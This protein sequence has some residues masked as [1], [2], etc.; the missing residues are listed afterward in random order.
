MRIASMSVAVLSAAMVASP[1]SAALLSVDFNS[2]QSSVPSPGTQPGFEGAVVG[3]FESTPLAYTFG[4]YTVSTEDTVVDSDGNFTQSGSRN[5]SV[6]DPAVAPLFGDFLFA[7]SS[8][9]GRF[10]LK[11]EGLDANTTYDVT[12]WSYDANSSRAVNISQV[13][14]PLVAG[15]IAWVGAVQPDDLSDYSLTLSA[16]SDVAGTLFF[17]VANPLGADAV[18]NGF[19]IAVPEPG[20]LMLAGFGGALLLVRRRA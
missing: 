13:G 14:S 17:E 10:G 7:N 8:N 12:F 2:D 5:R 20:A 9:G 18:L 6:S 4:G 16:T 3:V 15:S 19:E 11:I 1:G